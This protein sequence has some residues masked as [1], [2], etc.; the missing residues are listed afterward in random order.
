MFS[1]AHPFWS[2]GFRPFFT[3]ACLAGVVLPNVWVLVFRGTLV[4]PVSAISPVQW[5]AHEMFY[6]FGWAVLGGF[7][8]T[9][10]KNWV[11]VR[12]HHGGVLM[13]L[14][15]AWL[16]ERGVLAFGGGLPPALFWLGSQVFLVSLVGLL[17]ATLLANRDTD[18]F[19]RDNAFFL[20]IL[21]TFALAKV[22]ILLPETYR[23]GATMTLG[24]FRV[25]FLVMLER[26]LTQFM[27]GVF[28]VDILRNPALDTLIKGLGVVLVGVWLVPAHVGAGLSLSLAALLLGRLAFWHPLKA[29][30]RPDI[31][32]MYLGYLAIVAQLLI[33]AASSAFDVAWVG[34][35]SVHT[36][37]FGAMG[38]VIP[39]M[40]IRISNGHTGRKVVFGA[41]EYVVLGLMIVAFVSR[42]I[43][44]QLAP[45]DY[46]RWLDIAATCWLAAFAMLGWRFIPFYL[47]PRIDGKAH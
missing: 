33:E 15:A 41:Y 37:T 43:V 34:A 6:G 28:E 29:L 36:F 21:P 35:V 23:L 47:H 2:V 32:I 19:R 44:P 9:S 7:L 5:H 25:A 1:R 8:L 42:V 31:G 18:T 38:L 24:L 22:L 46:L 14:V 12:G 39:A 40:I 45:G 20:V 27:K 3:L 26:T 10:T 30:G 4:L 13:A 16:L 11:K 17:L